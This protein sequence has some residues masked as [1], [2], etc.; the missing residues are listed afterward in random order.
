MVGVCIHILDVDFRDRHFRPSSHRV[1]ARRVREGRRLR[2]VCEHAAIDLYEHR[3]PR[4]HVVAIAVRLPIGPFRITVRV[5]ERAE[6][7]RAGL[8]AENDDVRLDVTD[9]R[10]IV[11]ISHIPLTRRHASEVW[12]RE[13]LDADEAPNRCGCHIARTEVANLGLDL[14]VVTDRSKRA[15]GFK[16]ELLARRT[17]RRRELRVKH[18]DCP[19]VVVRRG[20]DPPARSHHVGIERRGPRVA[21]VRI[22]RG[23]EPV[24]GIVYERTASAGSVNA[25]AEGRVHLTDRAVVPPCERRLREFYPTD[26]R[27]KRTCRLRRIEQIDESCRE[28]VVDLGRYDRPVPD[29]DA[30]GGRRNGTTPQPRSLR[31]QSAPFKVKATLLKQIQLRENR[32]RRQIDAPIE[33]DVVGIDRSRSRSLVAVDRVQRYPHP[34]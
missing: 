34:D 2:I 13:R 20:E 10:D 4:A 32:M 29:H 33:H 14:A 17:R 12:R 25:Q 23:S 6:V 26:R 5:D 30:I 24:A 19:E 8:Q 11:G 27:D 15:G 21:S 1:R 16:A 3:I 22:L 31:H 9:R 7:V 28:V 18:R